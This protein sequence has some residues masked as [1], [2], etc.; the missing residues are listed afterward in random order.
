MYN[1]FLIKL[2]S[3]LVLNQPKVENL[4]IYLSKNVIYIYFFGYYLIIIILKKF[5]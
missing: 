3:L 2:P 5:I 1:T 4:N